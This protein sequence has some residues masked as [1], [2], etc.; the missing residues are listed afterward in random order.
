MSEMEVYWAYMEEK[1]LGCETMIKGIVVEKNI[2]TIDK[3]LL[4]CKTA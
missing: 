2:I 1:G 4:L 3:Y